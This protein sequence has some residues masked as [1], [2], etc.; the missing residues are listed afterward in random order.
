MRISEL[1]PSEE[2]IKICGWVVKHYTTKN[3]TFI[4]I[5]DG[6]DNLDHI[7]VVYPS[8]SLY[9]TSDIHQQAYVQVTGI[10]KELPK[11]VRSYHPWE[12]V[13]S[14]VKV[15]GPSDLSLWAK[16]PPGAGLD[17]RIKERHLYLRDPSFALITALRAVLLKALRQTFEEMRCV[18]IT[19]PSFVGN[20]CEGGATLFHM[21]H[22]G[23]RG[24]T[25]G[26]VQGEMD[27]YLSQSSQ[28]Y[29]E[30]AAPALG[31]CYCIAPSFRAERS[32]TKRHLTE[33]THAEA[34]WTSILTFEDHLNKLI[35]LLQLTVK[36]F[37]EFGKNLLEQYGQ[38]IKKDLVS[39]VNKLQTMTSD[40][41]ILD[42]SDAIKYCKENEIYKDPSTKTHFGA[43]DDIPEAAEREMID[44]IGKI[45]FLTKFPSEFKSFYMAPCIE[46]RSLVQ[47]CDVEVPTVGEII[48]SGVRISDPDRLTEAL[49]GQGLNIDDYREYIDLRKLGAGQTSGMGL[50][51]DRMLT[52]LLNLPSIR[53][54]V[55]FPRFPGNLTP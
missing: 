25:Y 18:E 6:V 10:L 11:G 4:H 42:H 33:F 49:L 44:K 46:D 7:Q 3:M 29:L 28:F 38:L 39:H 14:N 21:K 40:I 19:P 48:G 52:W 26:D 43:R 1:K 51:V 55:T 24:S 15:L 23:G 31:D 9:A 36:Y 12:M 17:I 53:D 20:Q 22:P 34:E 37:S 27:C 35:D 50:G 41:L 2:E 8:S 30:Y 32:H 47:G 13:A 5:K 16:C 45:V 54:V